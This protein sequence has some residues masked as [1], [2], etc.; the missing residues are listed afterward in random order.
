ME[1]G[2]VTATEQIEVAATW[3]ESGSPGADKVVVA[4]R[5]VVLFGSDQA[6]VSGKL[7]T[8][9]RPWGFGPVRGPQP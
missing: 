8:P 9:G 7:S 6:V 1:E 2:P 3:P 4:K 5:G